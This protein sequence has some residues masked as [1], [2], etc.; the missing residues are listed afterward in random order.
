MLLS[1]AFDALFKPSSGGASGGSY[2]GVFKAIGGMI[3][4]KD[5]GPVQALASGGR[6]QGPGGPRDDKVLL[7][8]SNGE[9]MMNARATAKFGP[10]LE[11]MNAGR[12]P[13]LK[14]G[15]GLGV[16]FPALT[17]PSIVLPQLPDLSQSHSSVGSSVSAPVYISIDASGADPAGLARVQQQLTKLKA[18][19]PTQVIQSVRKAQKSNWKF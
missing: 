9:F 4:L 19:I 5:G 2:G 16:S 8:G 3:G 13:A 11:A 14:D 17:A 12:L 7:W 10:L 1:A 18:E 15:G 6:V